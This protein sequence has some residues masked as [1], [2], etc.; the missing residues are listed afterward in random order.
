MDAAKD[1]CPKEIHIR[2]QYHLME[3]TTIRTLLPGQPSTQMEQQANGSTICPLQVIQQNQ[4]GCSRN[5]LMIACI[6][7]VV[8]PVPHWIWFLLCFRILSKD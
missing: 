7:P 4:Q 1:P 6:A 5:I 8:A 2:Q 3:C